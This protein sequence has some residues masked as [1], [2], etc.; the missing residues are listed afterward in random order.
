MSPNIGL[1]FIKLITNQ[2][3][4]FKLVA[5]LCIKQSNS[6]HFYKTSIIF[7]QSSYL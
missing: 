1:I 7:K 4:T 5:S 6:P 2:M 3:Q